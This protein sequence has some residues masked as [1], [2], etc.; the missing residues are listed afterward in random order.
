MGINEQIGER[1]RAA[2]EM[3]GL[4]QEELGSLL[5]YSTTNIYYLEKG[6]RK[7]KIEDLKK[8]SRILEQPLE[9]FI[10]EE[11]D[12]R[13]VAILWRAKQRL[14]PTIMDHLD[15]FITDIEENRNPSPP[16]NV[17][18]LRGL[19]PY[20]A[21]GRL[22]EEMDVSG[23]P[24]PV[25]DIARNLNIYLDYIDVMDDV[26]AVLL[27]GPDFTAIAVNEKHTDERKRFSLAHELGHVI[28]GHDEKLYIEFAAPELLSD[29]DNRRENEEREA[30]WFAADLLMPR[31]WV[32]RD[33]KRL[34][35]DVENMAA[36]YE[37]SQQA[38][39]VRLRHFHLSIP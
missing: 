17:D 21:A 18:H 6:K 25:D 3:M 7:F 24:V 39:W 14:S 38:M 16:A 34:E 1:I 33:W 9:Y 11:P 5:G 36:E 26:S 13:M 2:R 29:L 28:L 20:A 12:D 32:L 27:R 8:L 15:D 23:P 35:K 19:K 10:Q 37:V 22:L 31:D 4:S 30:N